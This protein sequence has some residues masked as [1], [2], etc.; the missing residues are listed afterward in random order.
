MMFE[1]IN[2]SKEELKLKIQKVFTKIRNCL[3]ER[4]DELL[5]DVD[6]QYNDIYCNEDMIKEGQK[7]PNKIKI[8]LEKGK[9]LNNE[10]DDD[11][12]LYLIINDCLNIEDNIKIIHTINSNIEKCKLNKDIKIEFIP[13]DEEVDN[14]IKTFKSFGKI[15]NIINSIDSLILKN[16]EDNNKFYKLISKN[17]K[18]NNINL[19]F[20]STKD[21]FNYLNVVNKINNKSNLIFLYFTGNKRIFGAYIKSKLENIENGKFFKDENAFVF[22]L[23]NNK[24]YKIL[25]PDKAIRFYTNDPIEIGNTGN[26][27]GFF[28]S[29]GDVYDKSLLNS[30][31]IYDF[32]KNS[33]LT[34]GLN[35]L[36]EL[37]IF[38]IS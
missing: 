9:L 17:I 28:F 25:V 5:L 31:K 35:K 3:N 16:K 19:L 21:G 20:R 4:E 18:I 1:K 26:S 22:S 24:I 6:N 11:K 14:F 30:P 12:K 10:W 36:T 8:S 13:N 23:D 27:N 34:E 32:Q 7:L 37:E 15:F 29:S 33:E 2:E 38:E